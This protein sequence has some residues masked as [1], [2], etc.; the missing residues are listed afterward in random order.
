MYTNTDVRFPVF[1]IS[2][3]VKY[4]SSDNFKEKPYVSINT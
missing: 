3:I 4:E 2:L 1:I